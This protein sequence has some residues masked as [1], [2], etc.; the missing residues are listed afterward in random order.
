[1]K[2]RRKITVNINFS[3]RWLYTLIIIGIILVISV[4]VY[5]ANFLLTPGTAPNPGHLISQTSPPS[6]CTAGQV[7]QWTGTANGDGGWTCASTG[8]TLTKNITVPFYQIIPY[9]SGA[10]TV[11]QNA[12]C[13]SASAGT[14][15][16]Y[17]NLG[18][19]YYDCSGTGALR[20]IPRTSPPQAACYQSG[21]PTCPNTLIGYLVN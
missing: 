3:N 17:P 2:K 14:C 16:T 13:N 20:T 5:A 12:N 6:G 18:T 10:G 11:T 15:G 4:G 7:L 19:Y 8:S 9:C 21:T 1:M